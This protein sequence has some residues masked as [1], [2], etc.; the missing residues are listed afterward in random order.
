MSD[1]FINDPA[2]ATLPDPWE[3]GAPIPLDGLLER[4]RFGPL[5]TAFFALLIGLVSYMLIGNVAIIVLLVVA[6]VGLEEMLA[7][8][9]GIMEEQ[10][11]VMLSANSIG[12]VLGLGVVAFLLTRL[13]TRRVGAFLRLRK[14]DAPL[15]ILAVVG[16]VALTPVVQWAGSI[17]QMLPLPE[18]LQTLEEVQI[19]L[20]EKVL[21][22]DLSIIFSLT[23]MAV[24]PAFCEEFFFRGY[25]Q[26]HF[27]RGLGVMWGI[28]ITGIVFGFFHLRL[29]QVLPLSLLGI[30][31]AYLTWRT[32]SL[33]VPIVV[34][35]A[36][37]ALALAMAEFVKSRPDL[38][39][40]DLEQVQVPWYLVVVGVIFFAG[41][42]Y[43]MRQRAEGLVAQASTVAPT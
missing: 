40:A 7:D 33:W 1:P 11:A 36:N 5:L 28:V 26:R 27:E 38:D 30:Y 29:T 9:P 21:A 4:H 39:L 14:P 13:H 16:L 2:H 19:A 31:L 35:F 3:R 41:V 42:V 20:I 37:N 10:T 43:V 34:H 24:T 15:M 12:L 6:G 25:V 23:M 32:G 17:N 8:L 22:G 18:F